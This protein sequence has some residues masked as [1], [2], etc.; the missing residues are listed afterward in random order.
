MRVELPIVQGCGGS[1]GL[2]SPTLYYISPS[3]EDQETSIQRNVAKIQ[4]GLSHTDVF[5]GPKTLHIVTTRECV[6]CDNPNLYLITSSCLAEIVDLNLRN[7]VLHSKRKRLVSLCFHTLCFG[8]GRYSADTIEKLARM[9]NLCGGN[10]IDNQEI[11]TMT[12]YITDFPLIPRFLSDAPHDIEIVSSEWVTESFK[13]GECVA[14]LRP[15]PFSDLV[16]T[17]SDLEAKESREL[18]QQ[19]TRNGGFWHKSY[20]DSIQF[21]ISK[22]LAMTAKVKL[23]LSAGVPIVKPDWIRAQTECFVSP[24]AFTLNFWCF[25][26]KKSSLFSGKTFAVHVECEDR[27]ILIEAIKANSGRFSD[28]PDILIVPHFLTEPN[29]TPS[30]TAT[31]IWC[32]IAEKRLVSVDS[33][34]VFSPFPFEDPC[35]K[36]QGYVVALHQI[37]DPERYYTAE[38]LR[39]LGMTV[40]FR[41]SEAAHVVV[42]EKFDETLSKVA[43]KYTLN[44]VTPA[45]VV[46]LLK[47]GQFPAM[48]Q[49]R[50]DSLSRSSI[51]KLCSE[52][53]RSTSKGEK[54]LVS[55][56]RP[57]K[58]DF[59]S[60]SLAT[61]SDDEAETSTSPRITVSYEV[62]GIDPNSSQGD[63]TI[64]PLMN[65]FV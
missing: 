18:Q 31:W 53:Q 38:A 59:T 21:L 57:S 60:K 12:H 37:P 46:E 11:A 39:C 43:D 3:L 64:D 36:F 48:S 6:E 63:I 23:A 62:R 33:A 49:Y 47:T 52:L 8:T 29:S 44:V 45:W 10:V 35:G 20:D 25:T 55:P 24:E 9:I 5:G 26:Q 28:K 61:F 32:C 22:R 51:D 14:L 13:H 16:F 34:A 4:R 19:I 30:I 41:V 7:F 27:E 2:F 56:P 40:H 15:L 58:A 1:Q 42:A 65:M 17:S 54:V 50:Q